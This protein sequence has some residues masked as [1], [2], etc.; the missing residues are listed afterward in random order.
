MMRNWHKPL[1]AITLGLM[2]SLPLTAGCG[3]GPAQRR[4]E[5]GSPGATDLSGNI[6][7]AA[8]EAVAQT[9]RGVT[10]AGTTEAVV[11]GSGAL[12]AIQLNSPAPGGTEGQPLTG[13][14]HGVDYPGSSPGG[15][16]VNAAGPGGA[17]GTNGAVPGGQTSPST[18]PGG[19]P[20]YTQAVPN[21]MGDNATQSGSNTSAVP[22]P[23]ATGAQPMAVMT[24]IADQIRAHNPAI[25]EVRFATNPDDARRIADLAATMRSNSAQVSA[26]EVRTIW[27]RAI[28]AGTELFNPMYPS[29]GSRG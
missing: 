24:R 1:V 18:T 5:A 9:A 25:T 28:P 2:L 19:T 7:V 14:S 8:S 6:N 23:G 29:P 13:R 3:G 20:N 11:V 10:G 17:P 21:A 12:L 22:V 26:E 16:P 4:P 27:T 15:G